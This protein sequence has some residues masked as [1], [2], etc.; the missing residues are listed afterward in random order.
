MIQISSGP[1]LSNVN[2]MLSIWQNAN[3]ENFAQL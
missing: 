1:L 3:F 2:D